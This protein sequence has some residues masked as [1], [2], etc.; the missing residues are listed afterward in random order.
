MTTSFPNAPSSS[1][2]HHG[3]MRPPRTTRN[4]RWGSTNSSSL[5]PCAPCTDRSRGGIIQVGGFTPWPY[6]Y[7]SHAKPPGKHEGVPTEWEFGRLI[8][9]FNGYME[10]DAAGLGGMAN[11][12]FYRHY[13][14][15]ERY[16]QPNLIPG[17]A[18]WQSNGYLDQRRESGTQILRRALRWGL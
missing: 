9:Q 18:A 7:T 11:A 3:A 17:P 16:R 6:K 12:S 1:I 14:L 2:S 10:A 13:P 8:S 4:S 5:R 15:S